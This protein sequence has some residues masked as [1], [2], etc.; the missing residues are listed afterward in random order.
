MSHAYLDQIH[1]LLDEMIATNADSLPAAARTIAASI[2]GGGIVHVFGSGHSSM[3]AQEIFYRAG[4]LACV[5]AMLDVNLTIF[6]TSRPTWVERQEG[7]AAS[8]FASYDVLPGEVMLIISTSGI[9]AVPIEMALG[10]RE[11]GLITIAVGS[12]RAYADADSRH[13]SGS[14]LFQV[15]D[16]VLDTC[17]PAGDAIVDLDEGHNRIGAVSTVLGAA[18]LNELVIQTARRLQEAGE[19]VPAF[20]SQNVP[21]GDNANTALIERFRPRIP[22]MK[23]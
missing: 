14:N 10:A 9:N 20:R 21:G 22:L 1:T 19:D 3:L 17:V 12:R 7:Y 16:L 18:L 8:I 23:P 6:G 15:A 4:G 11:R 5:N 13:S 2:P